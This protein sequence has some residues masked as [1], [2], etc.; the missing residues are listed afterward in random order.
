MY[1]ITPI[2]LTRITKIKYEKNKKLNQKF[3]IYTS[4]RLYPI[5][6]TNL[7]SNSILLMSRYYGCSFN[8]SSSQSI[9]QHF[10][11]HVISASSIQSS[12]HS[13]WAP[14]SGHFFFPL[15][16]C[17]G[18][19]D[20]IIIQINLFEHNNISYHNY[21]PFLIYNCIKS[22]SIKCDYKTLFQK[23]GK[24]MWMILQTLNEE[25]RKNIIV[26]ARNGVIVLH[27]FIPCFP[28]IRGLSLFL[29][30]EI[31]YQVYRNFL[32]E[33]ALFK[34][35]PILS[36][37]LLYED[38]INII[39]QYYTDP[40]TLIPTVQPYISHVFLTNHC[41]E[42]L[43]RSSY[44]IPFPDQLYK[45]FRHEELFYLSELSL[46]I[47]QI[48]WMI[49]KPGQEGEF[50]T[51]S[52]E[53]LKYAQLKNYHETIK[54][55]DHNYFYIID[56]LQHD[57]P[58]SS[59]TSHI[60]YYTCTF[61]PWDKFK[62]GKTNYS[63]VLNQILN[64]KNVEKKS[65]IEEGCVVSNNDKSFKNIAIDETLDGSKYDPTLCIYL[66]DHIPKD[67][68]IHVFFVCPNFLSYDGGFFKVE[69]SFF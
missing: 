51:I 47:S 15:Q 6:L 10:K 57:L 32:Y 8:P 34:N 69:H 3:H 64:F 2:T 46:P 62:K 36:D 44:K 35:I 14:G 25:E 55:G 30:L 29:D 67:A 17:G 27:P 4:N 26:G 58:I 16:K 13:E 22:I 41:E 20:R 68:K 18:M 28:D 24:Q 45:E 38:I 19:I 43:N 60:A 66:N 1:I 37:C 50:Y 31:D 65:D 59:H 33:M 7:S 5:D 49:E 53:P 61:Q 54:C 56:K 48:Y 23:T 21:S 11:P 9:L 40:L 12:P 52:D 42:Y 63:Q 39:N